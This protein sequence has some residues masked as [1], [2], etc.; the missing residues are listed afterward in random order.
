MQVPGQKQCEC[1]HVFGAKDLS[2]LL[3]VIASGALWS[4]RKARRRVHKL[5]AKLK[6]ARAVNRMPRDDS[7]RSVP[8]LRSGLR[9]R[10]MAVEDYTEI[11]AKC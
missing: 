7:G 3:L 6:S 5:D 10:S 9:W 11:Y 4:T 2:N 1:V 8:G